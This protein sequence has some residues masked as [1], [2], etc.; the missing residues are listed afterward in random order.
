MVKIK[1]FDKKLIF[2]FFSLF[3]FLFILHSQVLFSEEEN[4]KEVSNQAIE[5]KESQISPE[6]ITVSP[7]SKDLNISKEDTFVLPG[8]NGGF[9]LYIKAKED[10]KSVLLTETTQDPKLKLHNY[11]YR[12]PYFNEINGHEKRMLNG[13]IL[14]ISKGLYSLIDS[15]VEENTPIG[16]AFHIW[17]PR[18]IVYGYSWSRNGELEVVDGTFIN[19]RAFELPYGDYKGT[20]RDNPFVLKIDDI[21]LNYIHEAVS[22]FK[23]ITGKT[24]GQLLYARSSLDVIP[25]IKKLIGV[26]LDKDYGLDLMFVLDCTESMKP[27][28]AQAK[29]D[30]LSFLEKMQEHFLSLRVGL[31]LYKDYYDDFVVKEACVFTKDLKNFSN[32]LK[33]VEVSG[34]GDIPEA[35]YEGLYLGLR[36]GWRLN[37]KK[38]IKKII[39]IGDAPPHAKPRGRVKKIDVENMASKKGIEINTILLTSMPH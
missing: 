37:D 33:K 10:I 8:N 35:V 25:L 9:H 15:T 18:I 36:E 14:D 22:S 11:A 2:I 21:M 38:V 20:F 32:I 39:L 1:I 13:E 24:K 29:D 34:G 7:T 12:D 19:I 23:D 16:K 27:H 31:I 4:T 5:N 6:I 30:M 26:E 28:I 3:I 17:I